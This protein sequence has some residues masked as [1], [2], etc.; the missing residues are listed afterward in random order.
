MLT[1]AGNT[2]WGS[3]GLLA[4]ASDW[5]RRRPP[6]PELFERTLKR[7]VSNL[8]DI[9][10]AT[11]QLSSKSKQI[12]AEDIEDAKDHF[13]N[14]VEEAMIMADLMSTVSDYATPSNK[15][16]IRR[17]IRRIEKIQKVTQWSV[18]SP[19][20]VPSSLQ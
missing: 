10:G 6:T 12:S 3:Y 7:V 9:M 16:D 18:K 17:A 20:G 5:D 19:W 8:T 13:R 14:T 15:R 2:K 4:F 1:E 11:R